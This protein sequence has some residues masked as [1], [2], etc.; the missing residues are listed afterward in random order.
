MIGDR[1]R[2]LLSPP[3]SPWQ[4]RRVGGVRPS[5]TRLCCSVIH[6]FLASAVSAEH[7]THTAVPLSA[8]SLVR[9]THTQ[10]DGRRPGTTA[11]HGARVRPPPAARRPREPPQ[12]QGLPPGDLP[13][14]SGPRC[15]PPAFRPRPCASHPP[16]PAQPLPPKHL[17][18]PW[19]SPPS[20][21]AHPRSDDY[22]WTAS[23]ARCSMKTF[24]ET[25]SVAIT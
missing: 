24:S 5:R 2:P 7:H 3:P 8:L 18:Y 22:D 12:T 19:C 23:F 13:N 16:P 6:K 10:Q 14:P 9:Q 20:E 21:R 17:L 11:G 1:S 15:Q 25:S 4:P